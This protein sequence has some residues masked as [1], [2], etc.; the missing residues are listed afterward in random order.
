MLRPIS[1]RRGAR[2]LVVMST[3]VLYSADH[4]YK[5][6]NWLETAPTDSEERAMVELGRIEWRRKRRG[7]TTRARTSV[8]GRVSAVS[9]LRER[10]KGVLSARPHTSSTQTRGW[11]MGRA[12]V[13]SI[14]GHER[15]K[16]CWAAWG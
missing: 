16:W 6:R 8:V 4:E 11:I 15:K 14:L 1:L 9:L 3:G 5:R 13:G 2:F 12:N 7:P 10:E